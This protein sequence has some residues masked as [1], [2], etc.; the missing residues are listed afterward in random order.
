MQGIVEYFPEDTKIT[1][2]KGGFVLWIELK[3]EVNTY[4]LY[5]EAVKQDVSIAPGQIFSAKGQFSHCLRISFAIPWNEEVERGISVLG[6]LAKKMSRGDDQR[7]S[8]S[9]D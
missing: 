7:S 4:R 5:Q 1:R 8:I 9:R 6:S 2:P 3:R